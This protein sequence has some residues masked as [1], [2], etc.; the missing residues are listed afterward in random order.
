MKSIA[1][2][3]LIGLIGTISCA[4]DPVKVA[5]NT[6]CDPTDRTPY[7]YLF[8]SLNAYSSIEVTNEG[9]I[10]CPLLVKT[11]KG[12]AYFY[13]VTM[14]IDT[15]SYD[16]GQFESLDDQA[17]CKNISI[18]GK[19]EYKSELV[20]P[21]SGG[22]Y[23]WF[24]FTLPRVTG[25]RAKGKLRAYVTLVSKQYKDGRCIDDGGEV[26]AFKCADRTCIYGNYTCN[27]VFNCYD[28]SDEADALCKP[29][30]EPKADGL[31]WLSWLLIGVAIAIALG[32]GA[33][34]AYVKF[35]DKF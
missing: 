34:I 26:T 16:C 31:G 13:E 24:T 33:Y 27:G 5:L 4:I 20:Q 1:L 8:E 23:S 18:S 35:V 11:S 10:N 2:T 19:Q 29:Q 21:Q 30:P 17:T 7:G 32:G 6:L 28:A 25:D 12:S 14:Y 9:A 22:E 15:F 3:S